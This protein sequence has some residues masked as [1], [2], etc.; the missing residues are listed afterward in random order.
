MIRRMA[1]KPP[2]IS[3]KTSQIGDHYSTFQFAKLID[4]VSPK[5]LE[6]YENAW[7]FFGPELDK[8]KLVTTDTKGKRLKGD[9]LMRS[10]RV[11]LD[12]MKVAR[13]KA[14]M[15]KRKISPLSINIY[16]RV[17]QTFL[18]WLKSEG[19][20]TNS[21]VLPPLETET[22]D[23]RECFREDEVTKFHKYKPTSFNQIRAWTIAE[24]MLDTGVRVD[25]AL[26]ITPDDVDFHS[27]VIRIIGKGKKHRVVPMSTMFRQ[28]LYRYMNKTAPGQPYVFGTLVGSKLSQRN[29][30]RDIGVVER[31]AGVRELSWHSYRHTFA[32]GFLRR[33]GNIAKLQRI[34]GHADLKTTNVYLHMLTDYFTVGHD[35]VSSLA[36]VR[37]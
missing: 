30:L 27:E 12:A 20:L 13:V 26:N 9:E 36:P 21:F 16:G 31:K 29:A 7:K 28:I 22:G 8:V 1:E 15:S 24:C 17:M 25:E 6:L 14:V 3:A 37:D 19:I 4:N 35:A 5:T 32:T 34:L 33:G 18:N 10:E 2:T 11:V 23:R